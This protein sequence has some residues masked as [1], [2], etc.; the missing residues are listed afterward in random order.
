LGIILTCFAVLAF[1]G[2][3]YTSFLHVYLTPL[4]L[5]AT[6][7]LLAI[8]YRRSSSKFWQAAQIVLLL[9][10]VGFAA[11]GYHSEKTKTASVEIPSALIA[12]MRSIRELT[13][14]SSVLATLET[15]LFQHGDERSYLASAFTERKILSEGAIYG[16]LIMGYHEN[17]KGGVTS[18]VGDTLIARRAAVDSIYWSN[19]PTT[20]RNAAMRY[21]VSHIVIRHGQG[22][23]ITS[24]VG[25]T[26]F[27]GQMLTLL[28]L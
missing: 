17:V 26:I 25:D 20:V 11:Y 2:M 3:E 7:I 28:K 13:D 21:G 10:D 4:L 23:R 1:I 6:M 18:P 19:D 27:H 15:G 22:E 12:D 14:T 24:Q 9:V 16:S 8:T 5:T